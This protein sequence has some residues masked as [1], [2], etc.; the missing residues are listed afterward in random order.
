VAAQR[1]RYDGS[2]SYSGGS[3]FFEEVTHSFYL[4]TGLTLDLGRID[5]SVS[6]PFVYQNSGLVSLVGGIPVPTGGEESGVVGQRQPGSTVGTKGKGQ[7]GSGTGSSIPLSVPFSDLA[8]ASTSGPVPILALQTETTED[9]TAVVFEN[10]YGGKF[11]DPLLQG[12]AEVYRGYGALRS[13]SLRVGVKPPLVGLDSGV[14]TGEWDFGTGASAVLA[15]GST[16]FFG[17]LSYWRYGD[18]P[19]LPLADGFG[20]AAGLSR[21]LLNA[22]ASVMVTVMG[23][24]P[25]VPTAEAPLSA[26]IGF[27]YIFPS[28]RMANLGLAAGLSESTP[29]LSVTLGWSVGG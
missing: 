23:A 21:P 27:G 2:I 28:G 9:S 3:Y 8:S 19:E 24:Q 10:S 15:T 26:S 17:D 12:S 18:L 1:L 5:L 20:Y 14:G 11:A 25:L 6:L 7:G 22:R 4:N 29:D 16:L 13:V